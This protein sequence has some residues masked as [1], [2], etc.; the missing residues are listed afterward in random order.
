MYKFS[1]W[2]LLKTSSRLQKEI[3]HPIQCYI[4]HQDFEDFV[5]LLQHA[6]W[7]KANVE[8]LAGTNEISD[9]ARTNQ[10]SRFA[11]SANLLKNTPLVTKMRIQLKQIFK[12]MPIMGRSRP[13]RN[14]QFESLTEKMFK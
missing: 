9:M 13:I 3:H 4:L 14:E 2:K 10:Q 5:E 12:L 11:C 8:L 7:N 6:L 1:R